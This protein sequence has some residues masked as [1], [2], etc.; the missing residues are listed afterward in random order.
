MN[1]GHVQRLVILYMYWSYGFGNFT[2][3]TNK[4]RKVFL[5]CNFI[6]SHIGNLKLIILSGNIFVV[7]LERITEKFWTTRMEFTVVHL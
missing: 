1:A 7:L 2:S 6:F 4:F 3:K 5:L